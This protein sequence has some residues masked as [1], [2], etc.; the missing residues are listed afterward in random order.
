MF[1][2]ALL[3]ASFLSASTYVLWRCC[4]FTAAFFSAKFQIP[5]LR[6]LETSSW[7]N[8]WSIGLKLLARFSS[9]FITDAAPSVPILQVY[10]WLQT[11]FLLIIRWII[12]LVPFISL[13][14]YPSI[15]YYSWSALHLNNVSVYQKSVRYI[16]LAVPNY[17][18]PR[19]W[20][21]RHIYPL[22]IHFERF[23]SSWGAQAKDIEVCAGTVVVHFRRR[24]PGVIG[25]KLEF[26]T[27]WSNT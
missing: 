8:L 26:T 13:I 23:D 4:P 21:R 6:T 14:L 1:S 5:I 10:N 18:N 15:E 11:A 27:W 7:L 24:T 19:V 17:Q 16:M 2:N 3:K 9:P 12:I 22:P 20:R 25:V